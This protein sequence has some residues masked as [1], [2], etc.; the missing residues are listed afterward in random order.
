[1]RAFLLLTEISDHFFQLFGGDGL[2]QAA[3][4]DPTAAAFS[5]KEAVELAAKL[6]Q[7]VPLGAAA[8]RQGDIKFVCSMG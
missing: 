8:Y 4:A 6:P 1:M 2:P 3:A 7:P 5:G